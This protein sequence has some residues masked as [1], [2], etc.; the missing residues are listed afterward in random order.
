MNRIPFLKA[1]SAWQLFQ[2]VRFSS[3]I[4]TNIF[5]TKG[6]L[7]TAHIGVYESI[8]LIGSAGSAFW[9]TGIMQGL[10]S[11]FS[12]QKKSAALFNTFLLMTSVSIL[13][14]GILLLFTAPITELFRISNTDL[15]Y[16]LFPWY[17]IFLLFN[18]VSY[19]N[20]Y[21][22]M[23][24]ARNKTL[25]CYGFLS[26]GIQFLLLV[27]PLLLHYDIV[28]SIQAL[29]I[30]GFV[31]FLFTLYTV[32]KN[33]EW[34]IDT[35][36]MQL[37]LQKSWPLALAM[38]VSGYA[39]YIDGW[40]IKY[41]FD[42][43]VFAGF[44]YGAREFPISLIMAGALSETLA[45]TVR[46]DGLNNTLPVLRTQA[47]QL[48][49]FLFPITYVLIILVPI[50]FPIIYNKDFAS[51]ALIFNIYLLLLIPRMLFPQSILMGLGKNR[52]I[53]LSAILELS[54]N[55]VASLTLIHLIG[56]EG[57][58]WG[59]LIAS[60]IDKLFLWIYAKKYLS[61]PLQSV[62]HIKT[63]FWGSLF[64]IFFYMLSYYIITLN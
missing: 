51:S 21:F 56:W 47:R 54:V 64:L 22:F 48:S 8:L 14:T 23:I 3:L 10:L 46:K 26:Y 25:L 24:T 61:V 29:A 27:L 63:W 2:I 59:T 7:S 41:F 45:N 19:L 50:L 5:F 55:V 57:A 6:L 38:L 16:K 9:V 49:L 44:M 37:L 20:E 58:A 34:Q 52:I 43:K 28:Q 17:V 13:T 11:V 12:H 62:T 42:E 40:M 36:F 53:L 60:V 1:I 15:F 32:R 39:N 4:A 33:A 35:S 30:L 31:K 18:N